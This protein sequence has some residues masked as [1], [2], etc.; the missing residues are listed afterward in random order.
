ML[1]TNI[2]TITKNRSQPAN[3]T[4]SST[5]EVNYTI[6]FGYINYNKTSE[7]RNTVYIPRFLMDYNGGSVIYDNGYFSTLT[8]RNARGFAFINTEG[9]EYFLLNDRSKNI[10][11]I[12]EGDKVVKVE[13][14]GIHFNG[15]SAAVK[16]GEVVPEIEE[17]NPDENHKNFYYF[18]VNSY[19][20]KTKEIATIR[21]VDGDKMQLVWLKAQ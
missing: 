7:V 18:S 13:N 17:I 10:I 4:L 14:K 15:L 5:F 1:F 21:Y 19:N 12:E 6:G 3:S 20:Q 2:R 8:D 9:K 16:E 11:N